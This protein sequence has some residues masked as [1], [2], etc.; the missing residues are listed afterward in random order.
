VK[1]WRWI[2]VAKEWDKDI[3][4]Y[5]IERLLE[6]LLLVLSGTL[7]ILIYQRGRT[8][9]FIPGP[10]F[11]TFFSLLKREKRKSKSDLVSEL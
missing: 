3:I 10:L 2:H 9:Y 11:G 6:R 8:K 7:E 4:L 5:H 1:G